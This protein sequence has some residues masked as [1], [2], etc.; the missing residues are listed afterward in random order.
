MLRIA[1]ARELSTS[2]AESELFTMHFSA[3]GQVCVTLKPNA[4]NRHDVRA[5]S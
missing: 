1:H 3:P 4:R 5:R 2:E